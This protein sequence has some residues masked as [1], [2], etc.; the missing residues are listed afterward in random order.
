MDPPKSNPMNDILVDIYPDGTSI[1][2][3][4]SK[5]SRCHS[6]WRALLYCFENNLHTTHFTQCCNPLLEAWDNCLKQQ[7]PPPSSKNKD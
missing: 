3:D 4:I 1:L 6:H 2:R 7:S 5:G